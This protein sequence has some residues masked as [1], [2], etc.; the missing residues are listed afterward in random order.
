M[1]KLDYKLLIAV[2]ILTLFGLLMIYS[3]SSTWA[4]YKFHDSFRYLKLQG[5]FFIISL[6]VMYLVTKVDYT[7]YLKKANIISN[8][9]HIF[10]RKFSK[11]VFFSFGPLYKIWKCTHIANHTIIP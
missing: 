10:Q 6:I 9:I 11:C 3:S 8:Q 1:K 7:Y 5:I 2:L 4:E